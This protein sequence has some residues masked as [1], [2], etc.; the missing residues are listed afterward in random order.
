[1]DAVQKSGVTKKGW[2]KIKFFFKKFKTFL[3]IIID[4]QIRFENTC[5]RIIL[6]YI[7]Q[8]LTMSKQETLNTIKQAIDKDDA[9]SALIILERPGG[10]LNQFCV[11]TFLHFHKGFIQLFF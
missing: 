10:L 1:M 4:F 9:P 8:T 5:F 2:S 11:T 3:Y 7:Y 6:R